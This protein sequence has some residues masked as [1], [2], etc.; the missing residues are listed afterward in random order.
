MGESDF[1]GL[2]GRS[3][4]GSCLRDACECA[5]GWHG[6]NCHVLCEGAVNCSGHGRC[7]VAFKGLS[8]DTTAQCLCDKGAFS[9][10]VER[11]LAVPVFFQ[12]V[13]L[14]ENFLLHTSRSHTADHRCSTVLGPGTSGNHV[15]SSRRL[16]QDHRREQPEAR[17]DLRASAVA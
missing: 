4:H 10:L 16:P 5:P 6:V 14:H 11:D 8:M 17:R 7:D 9:N 1:F 13:M 3:G 2:F 15:R 12:I